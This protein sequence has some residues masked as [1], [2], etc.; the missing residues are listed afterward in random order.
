[1]VDGIDGVD[2]IDIKQ[3]CRHHFKNQDIQFYNI[4]YNVDE[5]IPASGLILSH[6]HLMLNRMT[7][8]TLAQIRWTQ[9]NT[10]RNDEACASLEDW[11]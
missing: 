8:T 11:N 10:H 9:R 4:V 3:V 5:R 6:I 1:M 7:G 2:E